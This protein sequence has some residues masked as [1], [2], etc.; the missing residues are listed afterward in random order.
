[1]S[2]AARRN[3]VVAAGHRGD[4]DTVI[5]HLD[6]PDASVRAAV[7]GALDRLG[8]LDDRRLGDHLEHR[9]TCKLPLEDIVQSHERV[10]QDGYRGCV[11]LQIV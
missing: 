9:I 5:A 6:D 2:G 11:V 8:Q 1:M 7:L 10:E 3:T 4:A